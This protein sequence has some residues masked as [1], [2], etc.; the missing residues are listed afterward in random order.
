MIA[1][2]FTLKEK[3]FIVTGASSGIGYETCMLINKL[4]GS[5]IGVARREEELNKLLQEA[6]NCLNSIIVADLANEEA[7]STIVNTIP[8]IDGVVHSAGITVP[9]TPLKFYKKEMLDQVRMINYDS[10]VY[11]LSKIVKHKKIKSNSS[12]VMVA[13]IAGLFGTKGAGIYAGS[14]G[15]LIA[16]T[17]VLASE[18]ATSGIRV[19]AVAPG[20]VKTKMTLNTIEELSAETMKEDE[21]KYPLGYGNPIDVAGPIVFLLSNASKWITGE[22]LVIDGGRTISV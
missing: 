7:I 2:L 19:N 1:D 15:A 13:S 22:I 18:L 6:D 20:M 12:I 4:G 3:K 21:K 14:K 16:I 11:L 10:I 8:A 9:H 17:K 5:F